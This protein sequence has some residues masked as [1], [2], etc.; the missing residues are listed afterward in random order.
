M[1]IIF[2]NFLLK[3]NYLEKLLL[4]RVFL[5][6]LMLSISILDNKY[7]YTLRAQEDLLMM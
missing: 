1:K 7:C 4:S 2:N 5:F 6:P 3:T